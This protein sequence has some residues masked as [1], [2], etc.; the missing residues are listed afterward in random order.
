MLILRNPVKPCPPVWVSK[1]V[2]QASFEPLYSQ[3]LSHIPLFQLSS[4]SVKKSQFIVTTFTTPPIPESALDTAAKVAFPKRK[5]DHIAPLLRPFQEVPMHLKVT[6]DWDCNTW[7]DLAS[8]RISNFVL[9]HRSWIKTSE[10]L[11]IGKTMLLLSH[12]IIN[13]SN[14]KL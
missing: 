4:N 5:S 10:T 3:E 6:L 11:S 2:N 8:A 9:G 12:E 1:G 14:T 13:K 7:E